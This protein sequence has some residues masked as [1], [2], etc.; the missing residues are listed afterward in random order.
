MSYA[1]VLY[2]D[3]QLAEIINGLWK[4]L[5]QAEIS[6]LAQT[7]GDVRPHLSIAIYNDLDDEST[8]FASTAAFAKKEAAIP[9]CFSSVG[10]F[11]TDEGV[12]F[13]SPT[14]TSQL[15]SLHRRFY[16]A[17]SVFQESS[18]DYYRPGNWVPHCTVAIHLPEANLLQ[19]LRMSIAH[20]NWPL[21][22]R[23]TALGIQQVWSDPLRIEDR[24]R[25]EFREKR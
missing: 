23:L 5:Y 24:A 15:L 9:I 3:E 6:S 25:F 12:A 13:L 11:P 20:L 21:Y 4:Q 14:P 16:S 22:G 2:F 1:I 17:L 8:L 19:A 7:E 10:A 18:H